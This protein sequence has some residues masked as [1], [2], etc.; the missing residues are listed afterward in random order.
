MQKLWTFNTSG[1]QCV[2]EGN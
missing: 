2:V 1:C